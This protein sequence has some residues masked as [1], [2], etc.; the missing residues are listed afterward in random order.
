MPA[1]L[2]TRDEV[3]ARLLAVFR[4]DGYDGASLAD[5]SAATGLGKSS[6]YHHFPGG[7]EQMAEAVLDRLSGTLQSALLDPLAGPGSP[8]DR[9]SAMLDRID[10]LYCGGRQPCLVGAFA[11]GSRAETFRD[12]LGSVFAGWIAALAAC[13][14]ESGQTDSA[15]RLLA[16]RTVALIQGALVLSKATGDTGAFERCLSA[17]RRE[18]TPL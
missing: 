10:A 16:E 6:L 17:L 13:L 2:A 4:D 11:L 18:L 8:Q 3:V 5:L 7:K 1:A 15:A 12:R 9:L 14:V